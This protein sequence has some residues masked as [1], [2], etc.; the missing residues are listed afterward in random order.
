ML[1]ELDGIL[2]VHWGRQDLPTSIG[3][4]EPNQS[5]GF[6][7][8]G[9]ETRVNNAGNLPHGAPPVGLHQTVRKTRTNCAEERK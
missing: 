2:R 3:I 8:F 9:N 4:S 5:T 1:C 7:L 6:Y